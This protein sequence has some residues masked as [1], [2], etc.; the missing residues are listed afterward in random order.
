MLRERALAVGARLPLDVLAEDVGLSTF[1]CETV[2]LCASVDVDVDYERVLG[3]AQDDATRKLVSV[4]LASSLT[5]ASAM[6]CAARRSL[7][8]PYGALRRCGLITAIQRE[9]SLREELRL[10]ASCVRALYGEPI[11]PN[12]QFRDA[13]EIVLSPPDAIAADEHLVVTA[14]EA[15]AAGAL[16]VVGVWGRPRAA[17]DVVAALSHTSGRKPRRHPVAGIQLSEAIAAAAALENLLWID[18][19]AF[20][21]GIPAELLERCVHTSVP[22]VLTSEQA[23]RPA[24]LIAQ[25]CFVELEVGRLDLA[26]RTSLWGATLPALGEDERLAI[27]RAFDFDQSEIRAAGRFARNAAALRTNGHAVSAAECVGEACLAVAR[28]HGE[29]YSTLLIPRRGAADLVLTAELHA[30]VLEIADYFRAMP[31]VMDEWGFRRQTSGTGIKALFTGDSGT[32]KTLAAEV[33]A[34]EIGLPLLKVDLARIVSKWVGETEKN[35]DRVFSEALDS[36]AVL[37]FDEAEALFG[38]RSEVKHGTD[39]YANLEVSYLLQRLEEHP[40]VVILATNLRDKIDTAFMRRFNAVIGFPRPAERERRRIW[41]RVLSAPLP[42]ANDVD[43]ATLS[44]LDL[45]GAGIVGAVQTAALIA[46]R[47]E[48]ALSMRH[49]VRGL[50]RQF[51]REARVLSAHDLGPH[52]VHVSP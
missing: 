2:V 9:S 10:T 49:V 43:V 50:V 51:Q 4:D 42:V 27:A 7:L 38:T 25:R 23:W 34:R 44:R 36:H 17:R 14:G 8:G 33:I 35:L 52:A 26:R 37:F 15:L 18:L 47:D 19:D 41:Q 12:G 40:G 48:A 24:E 39:R 28:P 5:A 1:E 32:G 20:E 6:E 45:T 29:R 16:E 31:R 22:I 21:Q 13:A 3:Y 11:D 30:R 46:A